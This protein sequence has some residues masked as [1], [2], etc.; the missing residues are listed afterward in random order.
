MP[1]AFPA[2]ELTG[3]GSIATGTGPCSLADAAS[4]EQCWDSNVV[5]WASTIKAA[6]AAVDSQLLVGAG[7]FTYNAVAKKGPSG[8]LPMNVAD[9]RFPV[10]LLCRFFKS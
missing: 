9:H 10:S 3:S 2:H 6:V 5:G 1:R 7:M 8:L 4:R